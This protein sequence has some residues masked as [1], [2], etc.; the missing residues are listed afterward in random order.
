MHYRE[1]C[2]DY[3]PR[4]LQ[5]REFIVIVSKWMPEVELKSAVNAINGT[6]KV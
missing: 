5:E 4:I 2:K 3:V 6:F 1:Y